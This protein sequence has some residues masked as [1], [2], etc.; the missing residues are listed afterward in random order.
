MRILL[1]IGICISALTLP[2]AVFCILACIY[3]LLYSPYD[4]LP[5]GVLVDASFGDTAR[6]VWFLYTI[7]VTL[8]LI[9]TSVLKPYLRFY[10]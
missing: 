7:G 2:F 5:I 1:Y 6:P 10:A 4:L 9:C 8:I 3:A